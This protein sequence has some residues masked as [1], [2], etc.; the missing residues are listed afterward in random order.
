ML[1]T[2]KEKSLSGRNPF[3]GS[4]EFSAGKKKLDTANQPI[5]KIKVN[6]INKK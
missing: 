1:N 6:I 2:N 5:S 4:R 3:L